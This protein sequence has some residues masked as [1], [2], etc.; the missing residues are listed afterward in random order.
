MEKKHNIT[1]Y[2]VMGRDN[3]R[4]IPVLNGSN[5]YF[6][7]LCAGYCLVF[8]GTKKQCLDYIE[9]IELEQY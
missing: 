2:V 4:P 6:E 1:T 5:Q 3:A 9:G 8:E 7:L